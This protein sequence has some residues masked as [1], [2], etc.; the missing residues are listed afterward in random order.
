LKTLEKFRKQTE[1]FPGDASANH[2]PEL[3]EGSGPI[4]AI[5]V[6]QCLTMKQGYSFVDGFSTSS[7]DSCVGVGS[8]IAGQLSLP[9][10]YVTQHRK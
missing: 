5:S 7:I 6:Q 10:A 1:K 4:T 2:S 3:F 9:L 8:G